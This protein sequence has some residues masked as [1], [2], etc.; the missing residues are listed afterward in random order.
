MTVNRGQSRSITRTARILAPALAFIVLTGPAAAGPA[1]ATTLVFAG[2]G[3]NLPIARVLARAFQRSHPGIA[4]DVPASIGSASGIR[5]AADGAIAI[6]LISRPL[7][8]NEKGL[9]LEARNFA[10]TPMIIGVHPSV[11]EE[12]ITFEELLDIYR[13][14][15]GKWRDGRK[16]VVLTREPG[17][18]TIDELE[19]GVPGFRGV[20]EESRQAKRWSILYKDLTMNETLAKTLSAIGLSDLGAVTIE[21]HAIKPLKVNGVAPSLTNLAAGKYPLYKTLTFVYR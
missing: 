8:E 17:D 12:N 14:K 11:A 3:T 15:K 1:P 6:G 16:I 5:A 4:I 18:S 10:R 13:G 7:K 19:R 9:G 21:R 2:S 20:Y